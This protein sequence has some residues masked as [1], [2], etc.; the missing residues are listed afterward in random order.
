MNQEAFE[1]QYQLRWELLERE[2]EHPSSD[3]RDTLPRL[4]RET[5][6]HLAL[7]KRR[8]YSPALLDRLNDLATRSYFQLY[9]A[10]R[11]HKR[12]WLNFIVIDF[13][14]AIARNGKLVAL[15]AALFVLP[16]LA[17]GLATY[18]NSDII[19]SMF[20][21]SSVRGFESMYDPENRKIGRERDSE[22]DWMMFCYYIYNNIGIAFRTFATGLLFGTGSVFFLVNNGLAIGGIGGHISRVGYEETFFPFVVGH[23]AP[24]LTAIVLSGAAGLKIGLALLSPGHFT[25]LTALRL[26]AREAATI[27]YGAGLL[28]VLAAALEAFWSSQAGVPPAVKYTVGA[29]LWVLTL[30]Y[31]FSGVRIQRRWKSTN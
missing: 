21:P 11:R 23:G 15:S 12:Q 8:R 18:F 9:G 30:T 2:L 22:D 5:C 4:Y 27:V 13:P 1:Q 10:N 16:L 6:S 3:A 31:L 14:A 26:A 28:L 29:L 25:R 17:M 20:D 19:Y 7:A 24:E